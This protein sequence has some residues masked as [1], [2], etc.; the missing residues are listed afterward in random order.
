MYRHLLVCLDNSDDSNKAA[1]LTIAMVSATGARLSGLHVYAARLHNSRFLEMEDGLPPEYQKED[2]LKNTREVHDTLITKGLR[3]ISDSYTAVFQAMAKSAGIDAQGVSREGK[4]FEEI[5]AEAAESDYDLVLLGKFGL[6]K[7]G[8]SRIGS[9]AERVAR[10]I[11]KDILI[12]QSND[13]EGPILVAVDGSPSSFGGLATALELS[14]VFNRPVE[15]VAAFDPVFH[16]AAFRSIAGVLSE[17]AGKLFRFSEQEKLHDEIIDKGLAKIYRGH[18]ETAERMASSMGCSIKTTLLSGKASDEI[19]KY[20]RKTRPFMAVFGRKGA[21]AT[22]G[23]DIGSTTENCLR[24]LSCHVLISSRE[25]LPEL[26]EAPDMIEWT[27]EAEE[28]LGRI[29][30]FARAIV[31]NMVEESAR[32]KGL[33][34]ITASFM[35]EVRKKMDEP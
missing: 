29:P 4:N 18:L 26:P 11:R 35:R 6:G 20:A 8:T 1:S 21:H 28:I 31:K 10:R 17:E 16:Q 33:H 9:V 23:L 7:T 34:S 13:A 12:A 22:N 30:S 14:K 24:E 3:I 27:Q 32:E 19:I 5:L 25:L 2:K 15:A